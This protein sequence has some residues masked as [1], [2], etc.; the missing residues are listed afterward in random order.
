[1]NM[2]EK[3]LR[4]PEMDEAPPVLVDIGASGGLNPA[5]RDLAKYSICVAFDPDNREMGRT[6]RSSGVYRELHVFNR[7]VTSGA[8]GL[9]EFYL[10]KSP[11]CSSLFEPNEEQLA[12]WEFADRFRVVMKDT[13]KT[14]Q[15]TTALCELHLNRVDWFKT[16]SQGADLRLFLSLGEQLIRKVLVAEFEPG[17]IDAY[18]GEDK[19]WKLMSTMET[20]GFWM[21]DATIKGSTR[22]PRN[23][24]NEL[25]RFERKFMVHLL[26]TSPGWG[27]VAYLNSFTDAEFNRRDFMLGWICA[28]IQRQHGFA[29]E[30]AT[31]AAERFGDALFEEMAHESVRRIQRA[32][33]NLSAYIPLARRAVRR[34]K[35]LGLGKVAALLG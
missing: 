15:M 32:C 20:L 13:V 5:W 3:V 27:E 33:L 19:L 23:V 10:T 25:G 1:M 24:T 28:S 26:K 34:W 4:R 31:A 18:R 29:L 2:T 21:S 8:E 7:A 30:L 14:I 16:D 35:R 22:M 12:S 17:I 11:A 6:R 9:S